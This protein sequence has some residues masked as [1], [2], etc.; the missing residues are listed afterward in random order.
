MKS[1]GKILSANLVCQIVNIVSIYFLTQYLSGVEFG[2]YSVFLAYATILISI[3]LLSYD[4]T[5]PN[6]VDNELSDFIFGLVLVSFLYTVIVFLLLNLIDYVYSNYVLFYIV[7]MSASKAL[8]MLAIRAGKF[9][10]LNCLKL[11][12][13]ISF[14][15]FIVYAHWLNMES[16]EQIIIFYCLSNFLAILYGLSVFAKLF[17]FQYKGVL[18]R[19]FVILKRERGF[20][21][22]TAPS[23]I[24]NRLA[25]YLPTVIIEKYFG[26]DIAGQYS[27]TLR[28]CFSPISLI[29]GAIGQVFQAT[30][31]KIQRENQRCESILT[32]KFTFTMICIAFLISA[33]FYFVLPKLVIFIFGDEWRQACEFI[34]LLA[35]MFGLMCVI[36]PL[37]SAFH[38]FRKNLE[39]MFQQGIYLSI[40]LISFCCAVLFENI[41]LGVGLFSF[42][43]SMRYFYVLAVLKRII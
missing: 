16:L 42:F 28:V 38:V 12:P 35:P 27:L 29:T 1:A 4:K 33:G 9:K 37:T 30:L 21:F 5:I 39:V 15:I 25:Y 11:I 18:S 32:K 26:A 7:I 24:L 3:S 2:E 22:Y 43:S 23:E 10:A 17:K 20:A 41:F 34:Q 31:A 14:L 13:A 40:S 36:T 8:Q 19:T 6:I